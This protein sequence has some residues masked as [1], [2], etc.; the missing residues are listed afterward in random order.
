MTCGEGLAGGGIAR[1]DLAGVD[2]GAHGELDVEVATKL[3]VQV[4]E[5]G[6]HLRGGS[7][8]PQGV[9]VVDRRDAEDGHHGVADEL[10]DRPAVPLERGAYLLEV[11]RHHPLQ[12]FRIEPFSERRRVGHVAEQDRHGLAQ[13]GHVTSVRRWVRGS[14]S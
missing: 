7:H 12:D 14:E 9:V 1:Y 4:G 2:A 5:H 10:L 3:R 11:P 6:A 8:R 13:N